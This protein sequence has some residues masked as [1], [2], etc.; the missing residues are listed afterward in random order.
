ML[1]ELSDHTIVFLFSVIVSDKNMDYETVVR[2]AVEKSGRLKPSDYVILDPSLYKHVYAEGYKYL[3]DMIK[4]QGSE[5]FFLSP[6]RGVIL[7]KQRTEKGVQQQQRVVR[8]LK[9]SEKK[10]RELSSGVERE[11]TQRDENQASSGSRRE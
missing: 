11:C 7:I 10:L 2:K 6:A 8:M 5:W 3:N 4:Q 9:I 1:I